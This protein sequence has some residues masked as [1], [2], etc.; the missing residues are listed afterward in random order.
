VLCRGMDGGDRCVAASLYCL[1]LFP[2]SVLVV[3]RLVNN[4]RLVSGR[5]VVCVTSCAVSH[6]VSCAT[7]DSSYGSLLEVN[8]SLPTATVVTELDVS[9]TVFVSCARVSI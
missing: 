3:S 1:F 4:V 9:E 2:C 5:A 7:A 6:V 8:L